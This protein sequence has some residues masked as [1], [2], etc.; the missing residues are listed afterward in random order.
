MTLDNNSNAANTIDSNDEL[1]RLVTSNADVTSQYVIFHNGYDELYAVNVA[2]VEELIVNKDLNIAK[3]S[4]ASSP[5]VGVAKIRDNMCSIVH[6]DKWLGKSENLSATYELIIV[7]NFSHQRLGIVIKNV[8][9]IINIEA[10]KL[11]DN[12]KRDP[13]TAQITEIYVNGAN[14]LCIVFN[15]D[16]L[17]AD[18]FPEAQE[19]ELEK[20]EFVSAANINKKILFADDSKIVQKAVT[21]VFAKMGLDYE[22]FDNGLDLLKRLNTLK[23]SD[24]GLIISDIEM[25]IK[26]GMALLREVKANPL[27]K[28]IHFVMNT[29]MANP[30]IID[31]ARAQ[32]ADYV[33]KKL[34][35]EDLEA[36]ILK[37]SK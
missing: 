14:K 31:Q 35:V 24:V 36:Q 28:D 18:M 12:S 33:I 3:S 7:C 22:V 34:D 15:S 16:M 5:L 29:N 1:I 26:D 11:A 23:P 6:F 37:Y 17:I 19:K 20:I 21:R 32:G 10:N 2:K 30:A 9:G 25:P 8:I 13:K 4:D 27:T